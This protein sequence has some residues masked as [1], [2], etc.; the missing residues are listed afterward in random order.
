M[1]TVKFMHYKKCHITK[2]HLA[3]IQIVRVVQIVCT[4]QTSASES[5]VH[6]CLLVK[7]YQAKSTIARSKFHRALVSC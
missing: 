3:T 1:R 2:G 4:E 6:S 5:R 7:F